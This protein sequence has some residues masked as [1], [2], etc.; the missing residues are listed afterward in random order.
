MLKKDAAVC[1]AKETR[2]FVT[3]FSSSLFLLH[4]SPSMVICNYY[5]VTIN[6][7][8]NEKF[9]MGLQALKIIS[10]FRYVS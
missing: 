2:S 9:A 3:T 6:T 1:Y 4:V 5:E 7:S 10:P 8:V